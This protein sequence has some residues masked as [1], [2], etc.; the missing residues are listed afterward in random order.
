MRLPS[1][2]KIAALA[3]ALLT[4]ATPA[5]ASQGSTDAGGLHVSVRA[6]TL[7]TRELQTGQFDQTVPHAPAWQWLDLH[8]DNLAGTGLYAAGSAFL[9]QQL[10]SGGYQ[11]VHSGDVV[12]GYVG[13]QGLDRRVRIQ[14][15]RQLVFSGAPRYVFL[16]GG[17]AIVRLPGNL[18]LDAYGGTTAVRGLDALHTP[19]YGGRLAWL[20]WTTGHLA[21][22][23]QEQ[24]SSVDTGEVARRT[25]GAD[26]SLRLPAKFLWTGSYAHDLL[27]GGV[28][29]IRLDGNYRPNEWL[30]TWV[31]G[32]LRDPLAWLPRDSIFSAF[33][34]R[35]DGLVGAGADLR[36]PG[37]L[38]CSTGYDRYVTDG[39]MDGYR[40]HADLRLRVDQAGQYRLGLGYARLSNGD[41]GYDQVRLYGH[42][43]VTHAVTV[44]LDLDGYRFLQPVR[45]VEHSLMATLALRWAALRGAEVGLDG[46]VWT[47]PYFTQQGLVL[48]SLTVTDA[49][50]QPP[51]KP[52]P[53]PLMAQDE[54]DADDEPKK[55]DDKKSE[56]DDADDESKPDAPKADEPKP[57]AP[58]AD[59]PKPAAPQPAAP[60][61]DDK[62]EP[63][64]AAAL[65]SALRSFRG[66]P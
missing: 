53:S 38:S 27:G 19:V 40:G 44:A 5:L 60:P 2:A 36:T 14:A 22:A 47:N 1:L 26:F 37:A 28:Q 7:L 35:T 49:L 25:V 23:V 45:G 48:A 55:A 57:Q 62:A 51:P 46:Q 30:T 29:E 41:N 50:W 6:A 59:E 21:V 11:Q 58:K 3:L 52:R 20:P 9:T 54:E 61:T 65:T 43:R 39:G 16:D 15:G 31:R 63:E 18:R 32:E 17:S 64:A 66:T 24:R 42:G 4:T 13:W 8:G 33:V 56:E 12:F 10:A 34:Q